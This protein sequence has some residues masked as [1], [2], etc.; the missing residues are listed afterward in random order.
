MVQHAELEPETSHT[1]PTALDPQCLYLVVSC[2]DR[3]LQFRA[4]RHPVPGLNPEGSQVQ[5]V[6]QEVP[7]QRSSNEVSE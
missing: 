2:E 5:Y 3:G 7:L 1:S 6:A 4:I